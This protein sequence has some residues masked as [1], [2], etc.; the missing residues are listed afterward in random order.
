MARRLPQY[1]VFLSMLASFA[2]VASAGTYAIGDLSYDSISSSDDEFDITNLTGTDS[3]PPD[4]PITTLLN[5]TVVSLTVDFTSGPA[6]VLPGTDF[7][8]VDAD[9]DL[10]CTAGECNLFGDSI[11]GATLTASISWTGSVSGLTTPD[12]TLSE[13]LPS[14]VVTPG[15]DTTLVAGC[16]GALI[17]ADG[18]TGGGGG[19]ST[20][21]EPAAFSLVGVGMALLGLKQMRGGRSRTTD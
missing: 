7:T 19:G 12:T 15:C 8:V 1:F 13:T 17:Y 14:T 11:T 5:F 16:D 3:F 4:F 18:S 9:G 6:L 10:D 20:V 2:T 21:P